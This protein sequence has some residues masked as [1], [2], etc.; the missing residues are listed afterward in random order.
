M[1]GQVLLLLFLASCARC[2]KAP[3]PAAPPPGSASA[4]EPASHPDVVDVLEREPRFSK[5]L[6]AARATGRIELIRA[7]GPFTVFAP[8]NEAFARLPDY[9]ANDPPRMFTALQHLVVPS[10]RI[11][12]AELARSG[13]VFD[14]AQVRLDVSEDHGSVSIE[15]ARIVIADMDASNGV[16]H[17]VDRFPGL[18]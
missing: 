5:L 11:P 12:A 7:K 4:S 17:A 16:I 10:R 3:P 15:G 18:P 6:A 1:R 8:V 13:P 14:S 2:D 9:I